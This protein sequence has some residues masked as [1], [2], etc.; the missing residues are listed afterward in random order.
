MD[1]H[2]GR[3]DSAVL[4]PLFTDAGGRAARRLHQAPRTTSAATRARSRSPAAAA[5]TARR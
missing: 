3:T 4:V 2:G 5:T 1:V